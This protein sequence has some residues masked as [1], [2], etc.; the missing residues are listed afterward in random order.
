M[1]LTHP[2]R[3][4]Q[5]SVLRQIRWI[6]KHCEMEGSGPFPLCSRKLQL[7]EDFVVTHHGDPGLD[8]GMRFTWRVRRMDYLFQGPVFAVLVLNGDVHVPLVPKPA[9]FVDH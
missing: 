8:A 1:A 3:P 6:P 5:N 7:V 2:E 9:R 4:G